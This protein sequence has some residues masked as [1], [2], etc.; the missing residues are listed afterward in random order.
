MTRG[1]SFRWLFVLL[2]LV[3]LR[4]A[5]AGDAPDAAAGPPLETRLYAV[6]A[7]TCG[8]PV[9]RPD[10]GPFMPAPGQEGETPVFGC[11]SPDP[12]R[13][14]GT[15]ADLVERIR[16]GVGAPGAWDREGTSI[17]AM[18]E[19]T[20]VVRAA[21]AEQ[22]GVAALLASEAKRALA[23]VVVDVALLAGNADGLRAEGLGEAVARR[24]VGVRGFARML[25]RPLAAS[26]ARDGAVRA[27]LSDVDVEVAQEAWVTDPIVSVV[28]EGV[29]CSAEVVAV[30]PGR[31]TVRGAG[32]WSALHGLTARRTKD[33]DVLELP[34]SDGR[35]FQATLDLA[36]G[37]WQ[38]VTL[39]EDTALAVR[40]RVD[41]PDVAAADFAGLLATTPVAGVADGPLVRREIDVAALAETVS[42]ARG[43]GIGVAT[44]NFTPPEP[45]ELPEALPLFPCDAIVDLVR[46]AVDPPSWDVEGASLGLRAGRLA[47]TNTAG[48]VAA[49]ERLVGTLREGYARSTR[50]RASLL[51]LP[52]SALPELWSGLDDAL[53]ADGGRALLARGGAE[54]VA[55]LGLRLR[56]GQ[57]LAT[58]AGADRR[59]VADF[60]VEIAQKS[61]ISNP[62]VRRVFDGTVLDVRA[63]PAGRGAVLG[64]DLRLDRGTVLEMR[65]AIC[66]H[67]PIQCPV[68]GLLR[69]RGSLSVRSG[70]TRIAGASCS[71]GDVTLLLLTAT[72]D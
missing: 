40:A 65:D 18:G 51:R 67:G 50:V 4:A 9:H 7:L 62:V 69:N 72:R 10:P 26:S 42:H 54:V 59:Y 38:A 63:E 3:P 56:D 71:G 60:D 30:A 13:P 58:E 70:T 6:G 14:L 39:S 66:A 16:D 2:A 37:A 57:R 11:E 45:P 15:A 12:V 41:V 47:V 24:A 33:G 35:T 68:Y 46:V 31:A 43:R 22:A 1:N 17:A 29:A 32:W 44:S 19:S 27:I 49:V 25:A 64:L 20:L 48:R 36:D 53:V 23:T 52:L 5:R 28:P 21:A 55:S 34:T 8:N 61:Q